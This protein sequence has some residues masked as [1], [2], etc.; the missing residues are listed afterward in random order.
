MSESFTSREL[1]EGIVE[2]IVGYSLSNPD[3]YTAFMAAAHVSFCFRDRKLPLVGQ[4][5]FSYLVHM[6]VASLHN[7]DFDSIELLRAHELTHVLAQVVA[8]KMIAAGLLPNREDGTVYSEEDDL[9]EA[10]EEDF[11]Q[12]LKEL[13]TEN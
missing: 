11:D 4:M 6:S 3:D 7:Q 9:V 12:W 13:S 2:L 1:R 8:N 5:K 10:H